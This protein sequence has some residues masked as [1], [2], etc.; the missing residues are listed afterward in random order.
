MQVWSG[1]IATHALCG[2]LHRLVFH[3][4][5]AVHAPLPRLYAATLNAVLQLRAES[6]PTSLS[7]LSP[8]AFT[9]AR[10]SLLHVQQVR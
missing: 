5:R 3:T 8:Q 6:I 2:H 4:A 9:S 10:S 7:T 1:P